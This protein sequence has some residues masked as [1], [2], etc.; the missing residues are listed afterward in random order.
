MKKNF[1][2]KLPLLIAFVLLVCTT[3]PS[4][5]FGQDV[6]EG[7]QWGKKSNGV[8]WNEKISA[9]LWAVMEKSSDDDLIPV[10]LWL[11]DIDAQVITNAMI[12][13]HGLDPAI[14][15]DEE[16][17]NEEVVPEVTREIEK[18]VGYEEAHKTVSSKQMNEKE[19]MLYKEAYRK[20]NIPEV[21]N[22]EEDFSDRSVSLADQ[23]ISAEMDQY[24]IAKRELT[25]RE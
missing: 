21:F 20:A 19:K 18:L 10:W 11:T 25:S 7:F 2:F 1:K 17:F 8:V 4:T 5:V 22:E 3:L 16:R 6:R 15:E 23:A 12:E 24:V 14:Y 13:E 9:E